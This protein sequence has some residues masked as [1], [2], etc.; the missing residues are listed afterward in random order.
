MDGQRDPLLPVP[1][2]LVNMQKNGEKIQG[3]AREPMRVTQEAVDAYER[4]TGFHGMGNS[5]VE[6]SVRVIVPSKD[7]VQPP[8]R[9][10]PTRALGNSVQRLYRA[11]AFFRN[12]ANP[13]ATRR[14]EAP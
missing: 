7:V 14:G 13:A 1:V 8:W 6:H 10:A 12:R 4:Q 2:S 9:T 5:T 11:V 3:N